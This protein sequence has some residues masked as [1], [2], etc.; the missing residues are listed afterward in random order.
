MARN[1]IFV[2]IDGVLNT[3]NHLRRQMKQKGSCSKMEWCPAAV[4]NL[5][6]LCDKFDGY[7][8]V[9]SSWRHEYT[10][11]QLRSIFSKNGLDEE[12]VI[13]VTPSTAE[14]TG[15]TNYCRGHEIAAWLSDQR[16]HPV[17]GYLI[18]DDNA[19][20]LPEQEERLVRTTIDDGFADMDA[21]L[22]AT[23]ILMKQRAGE[24]G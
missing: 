17:A 2:D 19:S 15:F 4:N 20:M 8:V 5:K 18:L 13:G 7:I 23:G 22:D 1:I 21:F 24:P 16:E 12:R 11:G 9:S 10:P 14:Q 6:R 3:R